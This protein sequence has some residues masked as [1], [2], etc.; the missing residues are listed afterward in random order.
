VLIRATLAGCLIEY[1]SSHW[2]GLLKKLTGSWSLAVILAFL[3]LLDLRQC[4]F[5]CTVWFVFEF[6]ISNQP[7]I[8]GFFGPEEADDPSTTAR[9]ENC[10]RGL[11]SD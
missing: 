2:F 4:L 5:H 6:W 3:T 11:G 7:L 10:G 8:E 1:H 9:E